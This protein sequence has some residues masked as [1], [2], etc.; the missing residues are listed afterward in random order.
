MLGLAIW[1]PQGVK[2]RQAQLAE[3]AQAVVVGD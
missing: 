3:G 2:A 1:L